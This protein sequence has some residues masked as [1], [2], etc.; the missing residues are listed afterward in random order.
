MESK[1]LRFV[2]STKFCS[3]YETSP[4]NDIDKLAIT[5]HRRQNKTLLKCMKI[6]TNRPPAAKPKILVNKNVKWSAH[7]ISIMVLTEFSWY[8]KSRPFWFHDYFLDSTD[9]LVLLRSSLHFSSLCSSVYLSVFLLTFNLW[10]Y[11][12]LLSPSN[13]FAT[14]RLIA[15]IYTGGMK[16]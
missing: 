15:S 2:L 1:R 13:A 8:I 7:A 14:F 4:S 6:F 3:N 11:L 5:A 9:G 10:S 12:I 16:M